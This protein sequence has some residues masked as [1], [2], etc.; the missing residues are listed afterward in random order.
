MRAHG[1]S[2]R[3]LDLQGCI[4][5]LECL[6]LSL[7]LF[8]GLISICNAGHEH[9]ALHWSPAHCLLLW[10]RSARHCKM[11]RSGLEMS[12]SELIGCAQI[13]RELFPLPTIGIPVHLSSLAPLFAG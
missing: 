7:Q 2:P 13:T 1:N 10:L 8:N 6:V 12:K 5:L 11:L 9:G 4:L 3:V